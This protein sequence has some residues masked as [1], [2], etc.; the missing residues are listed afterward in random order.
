MRFIFIP[1]LF[2]GTTSK[3]SAQV[4]LANF[5]PDQKPVGIFMKTS[6][7]EALKLGDFPTGQATGFMSL[8][9]RHPLRISTSCCREPT[10][11]REQPIIV[12]E[13][14]LGPATN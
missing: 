13:S 10:Q 11:E 2:L 9:S 1:L 6:T 8:S 5:G 12:Y 3:G 4:A 14:G 7:G